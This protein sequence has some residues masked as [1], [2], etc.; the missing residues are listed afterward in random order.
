MALSTITNSVETCAI[1]MLE[2]KVD[3]SQ[4]VQHAVH[5]ML[6]GLSIPAALSEMVWEKRTN[7]CKIRRLQSAFPTGMDYCTER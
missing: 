3:A 6:R 1:Q 2:K 4:E 5:Y 7:T